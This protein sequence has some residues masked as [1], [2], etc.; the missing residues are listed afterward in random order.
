MEENYNIPANT[1][2]LLAPE[3]DTPSLKYRT[4]SEP[5]PAYLHFLQPPICTGV[6]SDAVLKATVT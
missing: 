4:V 6:P 2:A 5:I 3:L 1:A